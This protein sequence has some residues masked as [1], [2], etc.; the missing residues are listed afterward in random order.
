MEDT[1][2]LARVLKHP[3]FV[4]NQNFILHPFAS[5]TTSKKIIKNNLPLFD[6]VS[7][8]TGNTQEKLKSFFN[9]ISFIL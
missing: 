5:L 1:S 7:R 2:Y 3:Q 9:D 8:L 4:L 6:C